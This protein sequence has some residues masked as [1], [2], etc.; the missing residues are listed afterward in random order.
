MQQ[1]HAVEGE[2]P[3]LL[4]MRRDAVTK[5]TKP[6]PRLDLLNALEQTLQQQG[7]DSAT[8]LGGRVSMLTA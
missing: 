3:L 7:P 4:S 6:D 2:I 5:V 8:A 1:A